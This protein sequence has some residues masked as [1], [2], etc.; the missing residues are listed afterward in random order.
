MNYFWGVLLEALRTEGIHFRLGMV[1]VL[2]LPLEK[3]SCTQYSRDREQNDE[4]PGY[5]HYRV[6][7]QAQDLLTAAFVTRPYNACFS[8]TK[9]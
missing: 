2:V 4:I 7:L 5:W 6:A 3:E 1:L 8:C 9:R